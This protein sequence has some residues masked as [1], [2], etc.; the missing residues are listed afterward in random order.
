[1]NSV[2]DLDAQVA[3]LA[4]AYL[5]LAKVLDRAKAIQLT[6]LARALETAA[7]AASTDAPKAA[8]LAELA[9]NLRR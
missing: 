2:P 3:A 7:S 4:T 8:A 5:E 6:Q 9:R 1:M